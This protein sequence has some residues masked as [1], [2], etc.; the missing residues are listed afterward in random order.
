CFSNLMFLLLFA[1]GSLMFWAIFW[2]PVTLLVSSLRWVKTPCR[3]VLSKIET[4]PD[5]ATGTLFYRPDVRYS[6]VLKG[7]TFRSSRLCFIKHDTETYAEAKSV[8]D[9]YP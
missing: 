8:V 4:L 6:Y 7:E 2:E 3:I 9:K 1:A 5:A